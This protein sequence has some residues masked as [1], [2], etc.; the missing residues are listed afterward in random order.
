MKER[1]IIFSASDVRAILEGRKTQARRIIKP[2]PTSLGDKLK[3]L[4]RYRIG[5]RLWVRET[6]QTHIPAPDTNGDCATSIIYRADKKSYASSWHS[7]I[8]MPRWAS[9]ITLEITRKRVEPLHRISQSD[10]IAEGAPPSHSSID[11][12]SREFGYADFSRSWF[13]QLWQS[14][15][16]DK[17]WH[18]NPWVWVIEFKKL[19][20]K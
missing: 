9:R 8:Y 19:E 16:G 20:G 15:H 3:A 1:P 4:M 17:S 2:Q 11:K 18:E 12:I 7:P 14:I 13:A 6:W 10:A 5:D